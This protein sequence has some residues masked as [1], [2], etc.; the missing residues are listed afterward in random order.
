MARCPHCHGTGL[1]DAG[2][3]LPSEMD[4]LTAWLHACGIFA[5]RGDL[6]RIDQAARYLGREPKTLR[7]WQS[8]GTLSTTR[9]RGRVY[10]TLRDTAAIAAEE[11]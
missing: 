11:K 5:V 1:A 8:M 6:L 4:R 10:V 2:D 9:L 7:N 3:A